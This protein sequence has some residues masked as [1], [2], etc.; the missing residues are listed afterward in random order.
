LRA[1]AASI[2]KGAQRNKNWSLNGFSSVFP[3]FS[4]VFCG[5]NN[6]NY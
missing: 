6:N 2:R 3:G 4:V 1:I 5:F